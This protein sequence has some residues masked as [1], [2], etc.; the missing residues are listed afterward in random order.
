ML[1]LMGPALWYS[2]FFSSIC[3]FSWWFCLLQRKKPGL[4]LLKTLKHK[5][6]QCMVLIN[7]IMAMIPHKHIIRYLFVTLFSVWCSCLSCCFIANIVAFLPVILMCI[8]LSFEFFNCVL[9]RKLHHHKCS[10]VFPAVHMVEIINLPQVLLM[11]HTE[12]LLP[13]SPQI[14]SF[15]HRHLPRYFLLYGS[16]STIGF[17]LVFSI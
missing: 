17:Y 7:P 2:F 5:V 12:L 6:H 15:H 1:I 14:Y 16:S 13:I 11:E 3:G 9:S 8:F 4:C 10:L